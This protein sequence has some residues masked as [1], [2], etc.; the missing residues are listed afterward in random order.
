MKLKRSDC[1]ILPLVLKKKWFEM[2]KSGVKKEEYRTSKNVCRMIER[3]WGEFEMSSSKFPVVTFYLGYQ[4]N[5]PSMSYSPDR[6]RYLDECY[7]PE[8]GE[9]EGKHCVIELGEQVTFVEG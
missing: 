8:W 9:T 4:K 2:I 1:I 5:R 7:H 6:V 3:W